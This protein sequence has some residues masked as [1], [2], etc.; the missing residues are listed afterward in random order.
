MQRNDIQPRGESAATFEEAINRLYMQK[1]DRSIVRTPESHKI[2]LC[3]P[4]SI[5]NVPQVY[6]D[7]IRR[8]AEQYGVKSH[9]VFQ[10]MNDIDD[11]MQGILTDIESKRERA[12]IKMNVMVVSDYGL[13]DSEHLTPIPLDQLLDMDQIQYI[14]LSSGY[15]SVIP[16]ALSYQKILVDA[17]AINSAG[18]DTKVSIFLGAQ[19]K[20]QPIPIQNA[21]LLPDFIHYA[22]GEWT[23]DILLIPY[24]GNRHYKQA[25]TRG[26]KKHKIV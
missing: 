14:I 1:Y 13:T 10:A 3:F 12:G 24:T 17:D 7:S 11:V 16:Y 26:E 18:E 5:I 20:G 21:S 4:I 19:M 22:K 6:T 9:E 8:A 2:S 15:A 23:Q 25:L